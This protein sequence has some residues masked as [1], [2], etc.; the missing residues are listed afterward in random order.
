MNRTRRKTG[1]ITAFGIILAMV[2]VVLGSGFLFLTL[3]MGG[4][5]EVQNAVDAGTLNIGKQIEDNVTVDLTD[6]NNEICFYDVTT[7]TIDNSKNCDKKISLR[8]INRLWAEAMLICINAKAAGGNAGNGSS[9]AQAAV[10][11]AQNL[12]N[13]LY[14]KLTNQSNLYSFFTDYTHNNS[15][16]MLGNGVTTDQLPGNGWQ[17]SLMN[18]DVESNII[19]NGTAPNFNMPPNYT[20]PNNIYMKSN[21]PNLPPNAAGYYFLKGYT[22]LTIGQNTFWQVPFQYNDKPHLVA[23]S[24]FNACLATVNPLLWAKPIPN[25]YSAEGQA[26]KGGTGE[27]ARSWVLTNPRQPFQ[28]AIP[29]GFVHI[30]LDDQLSH[31]FYY[32]SG[33]PPVG[34]S[35]YGS[36]ETYGYTTAVQNNTPMPNGGAFCSVVNAGDV[37]VGT[38]V[39]FKSLDGVIF[40]DY[41]GKKTEIENY[42]VNRINEMLTKPGATMDASDLHKILGNSDTA[43]DL[44]NGERDFYLFSPDGETIVAYPKGKALSK[45]PWLTQLVNRNPDGNE[46]K[47]LDDGNKASS[48]GFPIITPSG[49]NSV[50]LDIGWSNVHEDV[51]WTTGSGFNSCL[52]ELRIKQWTNIYSLGVCSG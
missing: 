19:L 42:L 41:N 11:G 23:Q 38:D 28:L 15:V 16:R 8:R 1:S 35:E 49:A 32:P 36:P 34:P 20:L 37:N 40:T 29:H 31:W 13:A 9:N 6:A 5:K 14:D 7:D 48:A 4:Q 3:F 2:L 25:A 50:I 24:S 45:A 26:L 47:V 39:A 21:R 43:S 30:H 52:G 33:P 51:Y 12:S 18:R 46:E 27:K 44:I 17:T 22:P 10:I